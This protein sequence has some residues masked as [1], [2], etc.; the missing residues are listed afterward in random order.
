[1]SKMSPVSRSRLLLGASASALILGASPVH[2]DSANNPFARVANPAAAIA[3]AAQAQLTQTENGSAAAQRA[4]AAFAQASAIRRTM[5]TTQMAARAAVQAAQASVPNGLATGGL[6]PTPGATPGTPLWLNANAP[7]QSTTSD[8]RTEVTVQQTASKAILNWQT[9][10]VGQKTDV[11]FDQQNNSSWVVL[12]RVNDPSTNPTQILGTIKAPGTVLI[13]NQNGVIFGNNSQIN[14]G[15]LVAGAAKIS[16]TQFLNNGIYSSTAGSA[17]TPSFTDALGKIDVQAGAQITTNPPATALSGGGYVMLLGGTVS[18]EGSITTPL[19]QTLMAAGDAFNVRPGLGTN[20]NQYSTTRGNEVAP[21]IANTS[22]NGAVTNTGNIYAQQ[23]D[24]TLTGRNVIQGGVALSTTAVNQ[25]GTIHLLNSAS[26]SQGSVTLAANSY[27]AILPELDSTTTAL[28]SQRDALIADSTTQNQARITAANANKQFNNLSLLG[29]REDQSRVEIV[30]GGNVEFLGGSLIQAQGGQVAVSA[31]NRIQVDTGATIDVSGV[32]NVALNVANNDIMVNIQGNELRDSAPNRD[33]PSKPLY[34]QDV[35]VDTRYLIYVPAGTGGD[36]SDRY[37][38]AGG[39]LEVSGYVGNT[40]HTIGEWDAVGGTI[41]LSAK[42]VVAQSGS[43]FNVAGGSLAY[44]GGDIT[45]TLLQGADGKMYTA[46]DA[47]S[48]I[49]MVSVG[50]SFQVLHT[51]WGAAYTETYESPFTQTSVTQYESGYVVGRDGGQLVLSTPTALFDGDIEADVVNGVEQTS[52]RS[53]GITDGYKPGQTQAPLAGGLFLGQYNGRGLSGGYATDVQFGGDELG[54]D[55][56]ADIAVGAPVDSSRANTAWFNADQLSGFGLGTIGVTT[57]GAIAVNA[58]LTLADGGSLMLTGSNVDLNANVTAHSGSVTISN[59]FIAPASNGGGALVYVDGDG[60]AHAA[61]ADGVTLDLRGIWTNEITDPGTAFDLAYVNGGNVTLDSSQDLTVGQGAVI[62]VS[63]GG[64]ILSNGKTVGGKGGNV[65]LMAG[66]P[67]GAQ[68]N[69]PAAALT[70]NGTIHAD[71]VNG[72]GTLTISA[73]GSVLIGDDASL[74]GGLLTLAPGTPAHVNLTLAAP[75]TIAAGVPLPLP[76][77]NTSSTIPTGTPLTVSI[78]GTDQR[79]ATSGQGGVVTQAD[80][81]VPAGIEADNFLNTFQVFFAGTTVPAGTNISNMSG[82][83]P[84]GTVIPANVFPQGFAVK[85]FTIALPVGSVS[86]APIT[87]AAGTVIPAGSVFQQA[88]PILPV[89]TFDP[90]LFNS[91]FSNYVV[92][93][94][95]GILVSQGTNLAPVMPVYQ[96]TADSYSAHSGVDPDAAMTAWLPPL[97]LDNPQTATVTQRGGASIT[98]RSITQGLTLTGGAIA[99]PDGAS[100]TVDPGQNIKLDAFGQMTLDGDLTAHGGN[101]SLINEADGSTEPGRAFDSSGNS[102]AFSLWVGNN[103]AIDVSGIAHTATDQF[104]RSYGLATNGG[105]IDIGGTMILSTISNAYASTQGYV[106]IRPGAELNADGAQITV[107]PMA[108]AVT[109]KSGGALNIATNGGSI[110]LDSFSGLYLDG[111]MHAHAGGAGGQGGSLSVTLEVPVYST[112]FNIIAASDLPLETLTVVQKQSASMLPA[113]IAA[114]T[115]PQALVLGQASVSADSINAGGFANVTLNSRDFLTFSGDVSLNASQSITLI[116]GAITSAPFSAVRPVAGDD[117][118]TGHVTISAPYVFLNSPTIVKA[119]NSYTGIIGAPGVLAAPTDAIFEIDADQ[120]DLQGAISFSAGTFLTSTENGFDT[121][122]APGYADVRLDS[123]GDIRFL[124]P[125]ANQQSYTS[126]AT[127]GDLDFIAAQIYPATNTIAYIVAADGLDGPST[128]T[129]AR[130]SNVTPD[131]PLSVFG[132]LTLAAGIIDQGGI[133]RAPLGQLTL[134]SN[135]GGFHGT[136]GAS[137]QELDLLPGGIS[138]ISDAGLV[139]P[140]GGTPDGINYSYNGAPVSISSQ[141]T[142]LSLESGVINVSQGALLDTSG[143]ATVAGAAFIPGRGGS[144]DV[145]KTPLINANPKTPFSASTDKVYAIIPG[146]DTAYAPVSPEKGAGDPVIGQQVTIPAGVPGLAAGTYTLLPSNYALLPG[147]FRV[148]IGKTAS[149]LA[150]GVSTIGTGTYVTSGYTGIANSSAKSSLPSTLLITSGTNVRSLSQY[151][152][153]SYSD[154]VIANAGTIA[155]NNFNGLHIQL[156]ADAGSFNLGFET[157]NTPTTDPVFTFH[158]QLVEKGGAGGSDGSVNIFG[159][160]D[161]EIYADKPTDNFTGT[162]IS[163]ADVAALTAPSLGLSGSDIFIRPDVTVQSSQI[164]LT[165]GATID[166]G[167]GATLSTIGMGNAPTTGLGNRTTTSTTLALSNG[168]IDYTSSTGTG[169]IIVEDGASLFAGNTLAFATNGPSMIDNGAHFGAQ[170]IALAVSTVNIGDAADIAAAGNPAGLVFDQ[171]LFNF[172]IQ[173]DPTHGAP[174]LQQLTL[175]AS[176][177]VNVFGSASLDASGSGVDLVLTTPAIYGYGSADDHAVIAAGKITWKGIANAT[178]PAILAGG[179]GTGASTLDIKAD[180]IDLGTFLDGDSNNY[181]RT[182]YG[183]GTVNLDAA[184]QIVSAGNGR[185][186]IYQAPS[187]AA[188][189]I[190]GQSGTG[191]NLNLITPVLTGAQNS[192]FAY[193]AGGTI[194]VTSPVAAVS[195]ATAPVSGA[196]IDLNAD[197]VVIDS[198]I[199]LP[200]G[201]LVVNAIHDIDLGADS[202]INLA[203]R[204]SQIQDKTVYGFG[205]TANLSSLSGNITQ[206]AGSIIDVSAIQANAGTVSFSAAQGAVSIGGTLKG[207]ADTGFT[208]SDFAI[209]ANTLGDF[210]AL[211]SALNSGGFFDARNFDLKSGD[212]TIGDGVKAQDVEISVDGGSLTVIGL[213]DASGDMPGTIRLAGKTGLTIASSGVLDAHGKVLQIDSYGEPIEAKNRGHVELAAAGGTLTLAPGATIDVSAPDGVARGDIELDVQRTSETGGDI[214]INASGPLSIKGAGTIAV[215]GF[216]TYSPADQY[217]TI[218]QDNGNGVGGAAVNSDGWL[219]LNQIDTSSQAFINAALANGDLLGRLAGLSAYTSAFHLRPG[220]EID[221][222]TPNGN[223]TVAGDIDLAGFRYASLNPNSQKTSVYGSGEP[224]ALVIRAGNNLDV[225]GSISD[226]FAPAPGTPDDSSWLL[227]A[228]PQTAAIETLLPITLDAGTGFPN[229][230]GALRYAI[231]INPSSIAANAIVPLQVTLSSDYAVPAGT[232]LTAPVY[233]N[234][235]NLLYAA[236]TTFSADTTLPSGSQLGAGSRMP[237]SYGITAMTWAAGASLNVFATTVFTSGSTT[238]PFEGII[239]AGTNVAMSSA[240]APTRPT[241]I[242]G[243]QGSIL[244]VAPLL[245]QGDLSWSVTLVAGADMAAAD[246]HIVKPAGLLKALGLSGNLTLAD[247]HLNFN[248][249]GSVQVKKYTWYYLYNGIEYGPYFTNSP[250]AYACTH[251]GNTSC[252]IGYQTV[253]TAASILGPDLSVLRTGTGN[254]DLIAGGS[255]DEETLFGVYTAGTQSAPILAPDGSNPYNQPRGV[256]SDGTVLGALNSAAAASVA[257]SYAAWY[258]EHG[259]DV[260]LSAQGNLTGAVAISNNNTIF[261]DS[262]LV[263][264]WLWR[265]GGAGVATQPTA[266]WINYGTFMHVS[267]FIPDAT[268]VGFQGIGTLGGGN[269]TVVVGQN[270]GDMP[271]SFGQV[272]VT[273]LDLA[274]GSTGRVL[275]DGTIVETGGGDLTLKVGGTINPGQLNATVATDA[276]GVITDLRGNIDIAAG[277]YGTIGSS[278]FNGSDLDPRAPEAGVMKFAGYFDGPTVIPGDGTVQINTRGDL[279]LGGA[280]DATMNN[281]IDNFLAGNPY[282]ILNPDGT[283]TF[284]GGGSTTSFTLWQPTTAITLF[285]SGSDVA[286]LTDYNS[287]G[288]NNAGIGFYPGTLIATSQSGNVRFQGGGTQFGGGA[289]LEL[290]PS[291]IGQLEV[292][293]AG[294]VFGQNQVLA[295]SGASMD[296]IATPLHP[297]FQGPN[298]F[299]SLVPLTNASAG[300]PYIGGGYK[301][302]AEDPIAFG[303]DTPT[304]NLHAGDTQPALIYAGIDIDDLQLGQVQQQTADLFGFFNPTITTWYIA[305]KPFTVIAGRDIL[306]EGSSQFTNSASTTLGQT[307]SAFYNINPSDITQIHAGRDIYFEAADIA[308]P[309]TLDVQAGRNIMQGF[310]GTFESVGPLFGVDPTDPST[311]AGISVAAGVGPNGPD[312]AA[313]ASLYLNPANA[314]NPSLALAGQTGK[315]A[316][317]PDN[318]TS[319]HELAGW[320]KSQFG[321][322]GDDAGALAFFNALPATDRAKYPTDPTLFFWLQQTQGYTGDRGD[323]LATFLGL[324]TTQ[325]SQFTYNAMLYIWLQQRF[326]YSGTQDGAYA[327]FA[328]L[329]SV[330]QGVFV[331]EV[332]YDELTIG[333][334]EFNDPTSERFQSYLRGRDAIATLFPDVDSAGNKITYTGDLTMYSGL[335]QDI[336]GKPVVIDSGIRTDFGGDI[337]ILNPAGQTLLGVEGLVPG[338]NAGLLTQ[339]EGNIDIYSEGSILLGESR[340]LTTFGGDILGWS[341]TGDINSGRGS[342]T[343][344]IFTPPRRVYDDYGN[345]T[346]SPSVPSSGAGIGTLAP[347]AEVPPGDVDLIAPLGTIDAGEAGIRVSGNVNLAALHIVNAANIQVQGAATGLPQTVAVNTGALTAASS[348][349]SAVTT[350]ATRMVP[351]PAPMAVPL[352]LTVQF[353][354]WGE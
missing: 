340:I 180:E 222:S 171:A 287:N 144:V 285:S 277:A 99:I 215:N 114:G 34:N 323:A 50:K 197:S 349:A 57:S 15:S 142:G 161:L 267:G 311:G 258:P 139:V 353:L 297:V 22:T 151:D 49:D 88:V 109:S 133:V 134:G 76:Y 228:G 12:N 130:S 145:L 312:Y 59:I 351:Q 262:D 74:S 147:A 245:P 5:D 40:G 98:L 347:I 174:A 150:K 32:L 45:Q 168:E 321:Y 280:G 337:Q 131:M 8:G 152:E 273:P 80:W 320:L 244:A 166:I 170:N 148:E 106:I 293:A 112:F 52:V 265:Q 205:G 41:T 90:S 104:G 342:K 129:V 135:G 117:P 335:G 163:E 190:F 78:T 254:L 121:K 110:T 257:A 264:N 23:G 302:G 317:T 3:Q 310:R 16:D 237:T 207:T 93:G 200:S 39:L 223:L 158:G 53:A 191:G 301:H 328:K 252:G 181:V 83:F 304:D 4:L 352:V 288:I 140:Y 216:W 119:D 164:V 157:L 239:P 96:I 91:G 292:L 46:D 149:P 217:G 250:T 54:N 19:G 35:W 326:G 221:S 89:T 137:T 10:N 343:T 177:A 241:G 259:G 278:F 327:Y 329:P 325:R 9:F 218:V 315:A 70:L 124:A 308:G 107:D 113:D 30:S 219:G 260:L 319:A 354:G 331:R 18:N 101:I 14:V 256:Q 72:G 167:A 183:F 276:Y 155:N 43:L 300:S 188:G 85:P 185:L 274:V 172:L 203:G 281:P 318:I 263:T 344:V 118:V 303:P 73:P 86:A 333:G 31:A 66:D 87:Y 232:T 108:G 182:F 330:Q 269:L 235:G 13:M 204:S 125:A 17:Y 136:P 307:V 138:S 58:P 175:S 159:N 178:P 270:A 231:A 346:L 79:T 227:Q 240:T 314:A 68:V 316:Q 286:P 284:F 60:F 334:R 162:S 56:A 123:Q 299:N 213:I 24:I 82:T 208:S 279:A 336:S 275:P 63:S 2:A 195:T 249:G 115:D 210:A 199:L 226:G 42:E 75:V 176:N 322:S 100:I 65:T 186:G 21:V 192:N 71:G 324:S 348:A 105:A 202:R 295:M 236:G 206:E 7:T 51:R 67:N 26:D 209:T 201:R 156:P 95:A 33:D 243:T 225:V 212:L 193:A 62:D 69:N 36:T 37:Y 233:D 271:K 248:P 309:G 283:T 338:S 116:A 102:R 296:S 255:F 122:F 196:E 189:G 332:Y 165:A 234:G 126:L 290:M 341:A 103:A 187:A 20:G 120:I 306:G 230:A 198:D 92:N 229:T 242:G 266:W 220:V 81:V 305:A 143:G 47:P 153:E 224:G 253:S 282:T 179:P 313:F 94:G 211:N 289:S 77:S 272:S 261:T 38:T 194:S 345:V 111:D 48:D 25:R 251:Y 1:M 294:S 6:Q 127:P 160:G 173:G 44:Q 146:Y 27:T 128:L 184:N 61:V 238:V 291:P 84:L 298:A 141:T 154:F 246:T 28:D 350:M 11:N 29:D 169:A 55:A 97:F 247:Q 268:L 132:Q 64:G 339:G 214:A